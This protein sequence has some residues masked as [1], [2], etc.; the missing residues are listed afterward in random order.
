MQFGVSEWSHTS[1]LMFVL[2]YWKAFSS[3]S[4]EICTHDLQFLTWYIRTV[5]LPALCPRAHK[6]HLCRPLTFLAWAH[7][8]FSPQLHF[9]EKTKSWL[10]SKLSIDCLR[11]RSES[12]PSPTA[13]T[14]SKKRGI[15][16]NTSQSWCYGLAEEQEGTW[17]WKGMCSTKSRCR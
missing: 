6:V 3:S 16:R 15:E 8:K 1:M 5:V 9:Q 12:T 2:K 10:F 14:L 7:L 17:P 13:G 4:Q 11:V